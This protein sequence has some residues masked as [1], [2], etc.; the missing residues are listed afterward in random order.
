MG[1]YEKIARALGAKPSNE[2]NEEYTPDGCSGGVSIIW[3]W[4][5]GE[6]PPFESCCYEHDRLYWTGGNRAERREADLK[7]FQC[8]WAQGYRLWAIILWLA[9]RGFGGPAWPRPKRWGYGHK[10][11]RPIR[12]Y[13][14]KDKP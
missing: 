10:G 2:K 1:L 3:R 8:A 9:V 6:G 12:G 14:P 11:Y 13:A 5:T 4:I 7:L